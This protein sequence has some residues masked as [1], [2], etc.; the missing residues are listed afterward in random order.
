[1]T[2]T[3]TTTPSGAQIIITPKGGATIH[4]FVAPE[5]SLFVT[6]QIIES[7]HALVIV[8]AQF[9]PAFAQELKAYADTLDKP[10]HRLLISHGHPDHFIGT[11]SLGDVPVYA[12]AAAR[13][14]IQQ[15]GQGFIDSYQFDTHLVVPTHTLSVERDLIDGLTYEYRLVRNAE[16]DEHLVILLPELATIVAQ[17]LVY[18]QIHLYTGN[19]Q[20][21]GWR[22]AVAELKGLAGYDL[23]LAGHGLPATPAVYDVMDAYLVAAERAYQNNATAQAVKD[24]LLHAFPDFGGVFLL[25]LGVD[26]AFAG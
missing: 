4:T 3:K 10:I 24:E 23:L 15:A 13:A 22:A 12:S 14:F 18:N 1:M 20:L 7:A 5:A 6:S 2:T 26:H 17:D 19:K 8:D 9:I 11:H 16:A 25:N 21:A